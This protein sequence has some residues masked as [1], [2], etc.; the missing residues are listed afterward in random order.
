MADA[1]S[2]EVLKTK[3]NEIFRTK[4][5]LENYSNNTLRNSEFK[6]ANGK[7]IEEVKARCLLLCKE[8]LNNISS[9]IKKELR[10]EDF[11]DPIDNCINLLSD[12]HFFE[13]RDIISQII[14]IYEENYNVLVEEFRISPLDKIKFYKLK[15]IQ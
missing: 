4:T 13:V 14:N 2:K 15:F 11:F 12:E 7:V 5:I 8:P 10:C 1:S 6:E 3:L 9:T